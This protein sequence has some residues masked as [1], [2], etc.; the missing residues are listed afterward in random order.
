MGVTTF[1]LKPLIVL[2]EDTAFWKLLP[3][4]DKGGELTEARQQI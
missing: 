2:Q 3:L 4:D 1:V